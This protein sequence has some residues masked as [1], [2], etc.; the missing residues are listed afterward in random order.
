MAVLVHCGAVRRG[1][2]Y[3]YQELANTVGM[4]PVA[5]ELLS[6][7]LDQNFLGHGITN[8]AYTEH[9]LPFIEFGSNS[10]VNE[11]LRNESFN[12]RLVQNAIQQVS[13]KNVAMPTYVDSYTF[14]AN[15]ADNALGLGR[16]SRETSTERMC[17]CLRVCGMRN[18][19]GFIS[20]RNRR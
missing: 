16:A 8:V 18:G 5:S 3:N 2:L 9:G 12:R 1:R 7:F 17:L 13:S 20:T 14:Y 19:K 10:L 4:T 11:T 6:V 15:G